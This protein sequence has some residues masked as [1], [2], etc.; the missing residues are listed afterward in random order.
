VLTNDDSE[1]DG[2]R[3]VS[4]RKCTVCGVRYTAV[5]HYFTNRHAHALLRR[6]GVAAFCDRRTRA[7]LYRTPKEL[8]LGYRFRYQG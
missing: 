1:V 4:R 8:R 2:L 5:A 6:H 3:P 7:V